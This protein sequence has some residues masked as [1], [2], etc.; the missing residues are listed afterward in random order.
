MDKAEA[1]W[2][3]AAYNFDKTEERFESIHKKSREFARKH[4]H[5]SHTVLDY[6]CG[7]GTTAC[8]L[9]S[10]V[11]QIAAIDISS[12]MI[13]LAQEKVTAAKIENISLRQ[14]DIF[15]ED[16]EAGSF[17]VI[18]AFNILHTVPDPEAVMQRARELLKPEGLIIAVTP[19]LRDKLSFLVGLQ[20]WLVQVL[21]NFGVIPVP[22]RRLK[23]SDLDSLMENSTFQIVDSEEMYAGASSYFVVGRKSSET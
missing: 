8:D 6:G 23:S 17:D 22:I 2:D 20:I 19:T 15:D 10:G 11:K 18:L 21:C 4:L 5:T 14:G 3:S 9:A 12:K 1:F 13:Q 16:Y 7:T